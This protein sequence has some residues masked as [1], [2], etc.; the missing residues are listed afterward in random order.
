MNHLK[1]ITN[2]N[3]FLKRF[4]TNN[5]LYKKKYV[6]E[7]IDKE[8]YLKYL[9]K[10]KKD[11]YCIIDTIYKHIYI[12]NDEG[13]FI[14]NNKIIDNIQN[15]ILE[16]DKYSIKNN[17]MIIYLCDINSCAEP[18]LK[19]VKKE[20][21]ILNKQ[22]YKK[23]KYLKISF[24]I[25][26]KTYSKKFKTYIIIDNEY[27]LSLYYK[28]KLISTILLLY[29][30]YDALEI[31]SNTVEKYEGNKFNKLLRMIIILLSSLIICKKFNIIELY[32]QAV[33][34]ISAWLLINNFNTVYSA[35]SA[36]SKKYKT[37]SNT[38]K[39]LELKEFIWKAY[40][41]GFNF[42]IYIKLDKNNIK[43]AK[44]LLKVLLSNKIESINCL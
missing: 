39:H 22:I 15:N 23:C 40:K 41:N 29:N 1:I 9:C 18:N 38:N 10:L 6:L 31:R 3:I 26:E 44:K 7:I 2:K 19:N 42:D 4:K 35:N 37:F 24:D 14:N 13:I 8:T 11:Y 34:P 25:I 32:S 30:T 5:I 28:N 36:N 21:V 12:I 43:I 20:L 17:I 33:N 16:L 27:K